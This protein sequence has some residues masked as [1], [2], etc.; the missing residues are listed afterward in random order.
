MIKED[1]K[2]WK[3][4]TKKCLYTNTDIMIVEESLKPFLVRICR[5]ALYSF[6]NKGKNGK[7]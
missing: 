5:N 7:R 4:I 1:R 6:E 3:L 2:S